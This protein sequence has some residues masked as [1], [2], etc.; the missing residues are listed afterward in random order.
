MHTTGTSFLDALQELGVRYIFAN[1]GSDHTS[2]IESLA[3]AKATGRHLPELIVCPN[4]MVA[5]SAA[6]GYAQLTGLAQAVVV[7]VDC[8]TQALG[9]AVHNA[10]R[11]RVPVLI[12]AGASP[13]TQQG[14]LRG[15]RNEHTNWLQDVFDQRS[16][17][18]GYVKYDNEI[19]T[20]TNVK[21]LVYRAMQFANSDPRGP[22]YLMGAR[23]VMEE[24]VNSAP[25]DPR[26]WP[27]IEPCAL[28]ASGMALLIQDLLAAER[29]LVVTS[30]LGRNPSAVGELVKLCR[31]LG[32]GVLESVPHCLNYPAEDPLYQGNEWN[33]KRQ[34]KALA[35]AD[36]VL[37]FDADVPWIP[38][39]S[40]PHK[41]AKIHH[42]DID[43]IKER[44]PLFQVPAKQVFRADSA[45]ALRQ[46][47]DALDAV[48]INQA[49]VEERR[50]HYKRMHENR[51][52][53]LLRSEHV[54]KDGITGAYLTACVRQQLDQRNSIVLNEGVT[55]YRTIIDHLLWNQPGSLFTGG[56]GSLGW[57]GGAAIGMK[58]ANPEATVVSLTG[59][60]SYMFSEPACV[61]WMA[62]RYATPFLQIVYNNGGWRAPRLSAL[63]INPTGFASQNADLGLDFACPP[64]YAGIAAAAGG[65][66]ARVV[67]DAE[68]LPGAIA[69]ALTAVRTERR[70]AVIDVWLR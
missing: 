20:G 55:N 57:S 40:R 63:S 47:N 7:H 17:V 62:R 59:D 24:Q 27:A 23:E 48:A 29:P 32:I 66:F 42:I 25:V 6:H 65:A 13:I 14:E 10:A 1:L 2:I 34:N 41:D 16:I 37:L 58:L 30:Y 67:R 46:I 35:E 8:G 22:V 11:A 69:E 5:L 38:T 61:H 28:P 68:V 51:A 31:R 44:M 33:D 49:A 50:E 12:F 54:R 19:R 53:E 43:P 4:E 3:E 64:D 52:D 9:G 15:S 70:S 36:V 18:R 45:L 21:E 56:G 26:N 39:V 60:G